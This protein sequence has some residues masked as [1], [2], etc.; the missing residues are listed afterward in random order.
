[1][2]LCGS[3]PSKQPVDPRSVK[4]I[5]YGDI[6]NSDTRNLLTIFKI[7]EI[8]Y[9]AKDINKPMIND[10]LEKD[11]GDGERGPQMINQLANLTPV[12]EIEE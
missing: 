3:A 4:V 9:F 10:G 7:C 8:S 6:T 11:L 5:V 2:G 12:A 1:M